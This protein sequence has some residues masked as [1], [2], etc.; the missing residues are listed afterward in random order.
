[1]LVV[2]LSTFAVTSMSLVSPWLIRELIRVVREDQGSGQTD[3]ITWLAGGLVVAY[4]LRSVGHY[5]KAYIAHVVA[6]NIVSDLQSK[7]YRHLQSL[8]IGFYTDRQSGELASRVTSDTRDI[9]PVFAHTIPDGIVY[10]FM[11]IGV[12]IAL[13][14]LNPILTLIVLTPIPFLVFAVSRFAKGEHGGFQ[15]A[16]HSMGS[17]QAKVQDNLSGM[18][19]I[20]IFAQERREGHKVH[21]LAKTATDQRLFAL[22]MQALIPAS[23]ELAAGIGTVLIVWFGGRLALQGDMAVEDLVA[24]VLYLG[25]L[26]QPIQVLAYMNEGFQMGMASARRIGEIL[27]LQPDVADP[28]NGVDP[29]RVTGRVTF[30]H[31]DF[32]YLKSTPIIQDVS[33]TVESGQVLALVGPTG[34][35]KSTLTSLVGRFYDPQAGQMK[36]DDIDIRDVKLEALRRN[37]SMVLQDVFLFNGTVRENIRFSRPEASDE[38]IV[39]AANVAAAHNFIMELPDGYNTVVG[40]RGVKL[41]GGQKQRLAI[42]RAVLKDAPI[43]ILDEATSSIDTQTEAEIQAALW[44]L[45]QGRT[46]IV[47]AHR[48]STIRDADI[49]AVVDEGRVIERGQHQELMTRSGL[50]RQ[51]YEKQF[52]PAV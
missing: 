44:R 3:A 39:E 10:S 31:V 14:S 32:S 30:Q 36:I 27:S 22:R 48:L 25:L 11:I 46:S 6:W 35:G 43:L 37:I 4:L 23:V 18:K 42:A 13:F 17:L 51:L 12:C 50:Y 5:L 15:R 24:F 49:I 40:E 16:L 26:Y 2:V 33:L 52:K 20:Q 28:P 29:G 34:A 9:E 8:S 1:M 41:S 19:E 38:E 21:N 47:V 45:M 7:L